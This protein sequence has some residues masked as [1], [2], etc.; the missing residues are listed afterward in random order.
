MVHA[1]QPTRAQR[2]AALETWADQV[3][4]SD[5]VEADTAIL[6]TIAKL[7]QRRDDL[8]AQLV[9]VVSSARIEQQT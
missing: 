3:A 9:E 8:D 1:M 4:P 5:L 7:A 6:R 2:A